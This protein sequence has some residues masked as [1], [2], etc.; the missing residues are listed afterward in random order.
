[1]VFFHSREHDL[2]QSCDLISLLCEQSQRNER[3]NRDPQESELQESNRVG[4][5]VGLGRD[6]GN[7]DPK[8]IE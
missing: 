6:R 4:E 2:N 7:R 5:V 8:E 1:V 3:P